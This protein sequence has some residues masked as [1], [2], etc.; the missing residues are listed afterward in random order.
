[1]QGHQ[2]MTIARKYWAQGRPCP[3]AMVFGL[4][5]A[6]WIAGTH[7]VPPGVSEL[8]YAG[9]MRGEPVEVIEGEKTG[10]PIPA[11]AEIA[12]EGELYAPE[13]T[14][15]LEGP[16]GEWPGYYASDAER[17]P[18]V[19]VRRVMFRNDPIITG[20]PPL[21]PLATHTPDIAMDFG[22]ARVWQYLEAAGV[23]DVC[24]VARYIPGQNY[25]FFFVISIRQRYP[26]HSRQAAH[27]A[28]GCYT[29][30]GLGRFVIVVD[31]DI[32][33]ANLHEVLWAMGTRCDPV[34][35]IDILKGCLS[36]PL[37]PRI[38]PGRRAQGDWTAGKAIIDACRP[39]H[40]R[41]EFPAVNEI[42]AELKAKVL[43]KWRPLLGG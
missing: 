20:A 36:S 14:G 32:D 31:D 15:L 12:V 40:W 26:G 23:P 41:N 33:P 16:F 7:T 19:K 29:G 3:V 13:E 25:A 28:L 22:S 24:G 9:W 37:D 21:K 10:L 27:A 2:G 1:V 35:S 42:S 34:T 4:E 5:P 17:Q 30:A 39:F 43:D 6:V 8:E 38:E 11:A 18:V